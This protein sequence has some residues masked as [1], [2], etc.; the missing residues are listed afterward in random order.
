MDEKKYVPMFLKYVNEAGRKAWYWCE[1][2]DRVRQ[3]AEEHRDGWL[4]YDL[5]FLEPVESWRADPE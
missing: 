1:D 3:F 2:G 5:F 4:E